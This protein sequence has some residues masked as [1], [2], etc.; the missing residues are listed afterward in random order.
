MT[1]MIPAAIRWI[2]NTHRCGYCMG[3]PAGDED[4]RAAFVVALREAAGEGDT[5]GR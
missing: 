2:E 3:M 5:N 1:S 4:Q